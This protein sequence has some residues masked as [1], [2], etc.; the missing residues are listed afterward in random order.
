MPEA[1][2]RLGVKRLY[3]VEEQMLPDGSF[4]TAKNPNPEF[5]EGFEYALRLAEKKDADII[6]GSDPD[7][8][9]IGVLAKEKTGGYR[10]F[11][12]NQVGVLFLDYIIN[13]RRDSGTLPETL[14]P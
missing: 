1:L 10:L 13:A 2:K 11:S 12:G 7:S 5:P 3:C 9:R 8:D 14:R 4:P 6:L